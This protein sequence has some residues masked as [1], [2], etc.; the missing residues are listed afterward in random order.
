M[1]KSG[2]EESLSSILTINNALEGDADAEYDLALMISRFDK[3]DEVN[4]LYESAA[5]KGSIKAQA[6][7]GINYRSR[8]RR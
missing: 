7:L 6:E 8:Y 2:T 3:R 5:L 4:E 1:T